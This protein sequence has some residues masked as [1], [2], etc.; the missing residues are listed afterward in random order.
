[1]ESIWILSGVHQEFTRSPSGFVAQCNLQPIGQHMSDKYR[2]RPY[3]I[4]QYPGDV[5]FIP[6]YCAHQV[7][8]Y[9]YVS[10]PY[11]LCIDQVANCADAIQDHLWFYLRRQSQQNTSSCWWDLTPTSFPLMGWRWHSLGGRCNRAHNVP[12]LCTHVAVSSL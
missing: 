1:M 5:V 11:N 8:C 2:V 9:I 3:T 6:A 7:S 4:F 12:I 10:V